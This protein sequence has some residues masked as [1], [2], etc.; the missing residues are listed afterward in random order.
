[1]MAPLFFRN[2]FMGSLWRTDEVSGQYIN[3]NQPTNQLTSLCV[4]M[5]SCT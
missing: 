5:Y 1:M 4:S 3:T 2:E